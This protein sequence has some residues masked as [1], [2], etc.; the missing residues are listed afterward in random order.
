MKNAEVRKI[1][2]KKQPHSSYLRVAN[3]H[4][5][6]MTQKLSYSCCHVM[7]QTNIMPNKRH[8]IQ[9]RRGALSDEILAEQIKS[10]IDHTNVQ[11]LSKHTFRDI[12]S[13]KTFK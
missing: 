6:G 3:S 5:F 13:Y 11:G 4:T 9:Q 2:A 1:G 8:N 10:H 7:L 12:L